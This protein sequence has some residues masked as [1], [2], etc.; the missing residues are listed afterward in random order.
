MIRAAR[1]LARGGRRRGALRMLLHA[2]AGAAMVLTVPGVSLE[3]QQAPPPTPA[4]I[5][6]DTLLLQQ[7][8]AF[9]AAGDAARAAAAADA[10][11]GRSPRSI[12][13]A[14]LK[15]EAE[16]ARGGGGAGLAAYEAWLGTRS[17]EDGY[18]LRR[19]ALA[20]LWDAAAKPEVALDAL[21]LLAAD[22]DAEARAQLARRMMAG[23]LGE[24]RALARMGDANAVRRL[25]DQVRNA[26]GS[27]MFQIE[28][29]IQ[30]RS[31][32]AVSPL[33]ELLNDRNRPEHVAA[34]ADG[35]GTLGAREAIPE[36]RRLYEDAAQLPFVRTMAAAGL[37]KMKDMTGLP[38]LQQQLTSEFGAIRSHTAQLMASAPDA[39]WQRVVRDL[40]SDADPSVRVQAASL[41]A[42]YDLEL[43]RQA[44]VGLMADSNPAIRS[45]AAKATVQRVATDFGSIRRLL[46]AEDAAV[47][48]AAA[49]RLLELAR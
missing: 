7:G 18:L 19:A 32:L 28:A 27:K 8:W 45:L 37:F 17:L 14:S 21:E 9:L 25:I 36:L 2:V 20:L 29:L 6:E 47:Q 44:L 39:T 40:V 33:R 22:G 46:H 42:P 24:T 5:T 4:A 23:G 10:A 41:I 1:L 11:L 16:I 15:V 38:L 43:A 34:A 3:A 26:P 35:L 48:V 31:P 30:S 49:G 13:A 12:A